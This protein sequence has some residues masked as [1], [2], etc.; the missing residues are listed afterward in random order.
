M[1]IARW[2][3]CNFQQLTESSKLYILT[4]FA[5]SATISFVFV[6]IQGPVTNPKYLSVTNGFLKLF[7]L[8]LIYAHVSYKEIFFAFFIGFNF[9]NLLL[10]LRNTNLMNK[11][12]NIFSYKFFP[13]KRKLLTQEEYNKEADDY[14]Q[15]AL[16][17]LQKYCKSPECNSWRII[18]RLQ[19]PDQ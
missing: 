1:F 3:I 2:T 9:V 15:K 19:S 11:L 6:Y 13:K 16:R 5:I 14:T 8:A 17:D 10:N 4:Y 7:S 12:I 18:S